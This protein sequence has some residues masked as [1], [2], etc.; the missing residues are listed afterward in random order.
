MWA[1]ACSH[2]VCVCP[3]PPVPPGVGVVWVG[4]GG[5]CPGR[6]RFVGVS[7]RIRPHGRPRFAFSRD[8]LTAVGCPSTAGSGVRDAIPPPPL[9]FYS[10]GHRPLLSGGLL[11]ATS[12]KARCV[13][14]GG[15][16]PATHAAGQA[17]AWGGVGQGGFLVRSLGTRCHIRHSQGTPT[18]GLRER[19]NDIS[20][21][22]GRSGRQNAATRRNM[23]RDER[24]TV[25]GPV[26]EQQPDGMS[27]RGSGRVP[28][29]EPCGWR[30]VLLSCP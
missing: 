8:R 5:G 28:S 27:H 12:R 3:H 25:Q 20:K 22:T 23:R 18:T 14:V 21:S 29:E 10:C 6:G 11:R 30:W 13:R 16:G 1:L 4:L 17:F 7:F 19:G 2:S 15:G 9:Y 26:K 24:V